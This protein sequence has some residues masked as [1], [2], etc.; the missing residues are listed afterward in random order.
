MRRHLAVCSWILMATSVVAAR[1]TIVIPFLDTPNIPIDRSLQVA[2]VIWLLGALFQVA[3][4][5]TTPS[6]MRIGKR[7]ASRF[8]HHRPENA[9]AGTTGSGNG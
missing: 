7:I 6:G 5:A 3:I 9:Q 8:A 1:S 2:A 4:V